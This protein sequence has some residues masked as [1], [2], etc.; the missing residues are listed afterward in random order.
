[1]N[2]R[3]I[4]YLTSLKF[5]KNYITRRFQAIQIKNNNASHS[6]ALI[7]LYKNYCLR[8]KCLECRIGTYLLNKSGEL[9]PSAF[10]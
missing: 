6:Q 10:V 8:L 2:N 5:E 4:E 1:L 9:N 3:A 7:H